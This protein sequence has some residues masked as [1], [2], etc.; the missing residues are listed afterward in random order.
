MGYALCKLP[1]DVVASSKLER[2]RDTADEV[3]RRNE[4][5]PRRELSHGLREMGYG[6]LEGLG[7]A[8]VKDDIVTLSRSLS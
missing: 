6:D 2:A 5:S 4:A 1:L 3:H 8:E 7:I